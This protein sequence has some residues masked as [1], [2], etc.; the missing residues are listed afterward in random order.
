M[1]IKF[2]ISELP[3]YL[4]Q[5]CWVWIITILE[6]QMSLVCKIH[7]GCNVC[8]LYVDLSP[9]KDKTKP[10]CVHSITFV[11]TIRKQYAK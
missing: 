9:S 5:L 11:Y 6:L 7:L 2:H 4:V 8:I 1:G 10:T 3:N